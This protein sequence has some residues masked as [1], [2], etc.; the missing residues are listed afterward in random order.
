[1]NRGHAALL[2]LSTMPAF[3]ICSSFVSAQK[4]QSS[5]GPSK[6]MAE[7]GDRHPACQLWTDWRQMCSRTGKGGSAT[8]ARDSDFA[9]AASA[10]FCVSPEDQ[11][12]SAQQRASSLRYCARLATRTNSYQLQRFG[13][14]EYAEKRPFNGIHLAAR[15]NASCDEWTDLTTDKVFCSE[16]SGGGNQCADPV[17]SRRRHGLL[18]CSAP[19]D[20]ICT[21]GPEGV[22]R[23]DPGGLLATS[24]LRFFP[25]VTPVIGLTC[26]EYPDAKQ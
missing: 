6:M 5:S 16:R 18:V 15:R 12:M 14:A 26:V 23:P 20:R 1:M 2:A 22:V 11:P 13:C 7:F 19:T 9:V 4:V 3:A 10:P 8:C 17:V 25:K 24:R 21:L